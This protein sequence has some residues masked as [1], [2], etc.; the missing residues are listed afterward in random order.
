FRNF[1]YQSLLEDGSTI[2]IATSGIPR[3]DGDGHFLGYRGGASDVTAMVRADQAE[4]SLRQAQVELAHVTRVT[5]LGE[6]MASIAHEVNQPLAGVSGNGAACLR[7]L[8]KD[9]PRLDEARASVESMISDSNRAS[10]IIAKMRALAKNSGPQM[11]ILDINGVIGEAVALVQR[12]LDNHGVV[13][14]QELAP[15]TAVVTGDRIQL[16]QVIINL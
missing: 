4:K 8:T 16:Q 14:R 6:L 13:L 10:I 1:V 12:E 2:W 3:F 9:P 15:D 11:A 7:W 5:T